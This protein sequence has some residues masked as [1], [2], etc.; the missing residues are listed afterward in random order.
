MTLRNEC[1]QFLN[2][3]NL[4]V[5]VKVADYVPDRFS[6]LAEAL[7]NPIRYQSE[8]EKRAQQLKVL[9]DDNAEQVVVLRK[10]K[11]CEMGLL[12]DLQVE[13][14]AAEMLLRPLDKQTRDGSNNSTEFNPSN[15]NNNNNLT[16]QACFLSGSNSASTSGGTPVHVRHKSVKAMIM[17]AAATAAISAEDRINLNT[18]MT[19]V[20][21]EWDFRGSEPSLTVTENASNNKGRLSLSNCERTHCIHRIIL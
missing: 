19:A 8:Q 14:D 15:N 7:A 3:P 9:E 18:A 16:P 12:F 4:F 10:L 6:E 2:L 11:P 1:N 13:R 5:R 21:Q 17:N 20:T